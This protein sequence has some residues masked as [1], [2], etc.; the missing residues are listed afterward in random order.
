MA[1]INIIHEKILQNDGRVIVL[2]DMERSFS[3]QSALQNCCCE[4]RAGIADLRYTVATENCVDRTQA[5][6][7]T[8]DIFTDQ[9]H[10]GYP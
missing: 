2:A 10:K 6:Q 7:N 9:R 3:V 1:E 5:M 8:R 4:N